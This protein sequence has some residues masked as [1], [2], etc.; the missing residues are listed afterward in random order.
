MSLANV[1]PPYKLTSEDLTQNADHI[2]DPILKAIHKYE[3]HPSV[4][5]IKEKMTEFN[6]HIFS[7]KKLNENEIKKQICSLKSS[8][9]QQPNDIPTQLI[10]EN[11]DIFV[12]LSQR[13]LTSA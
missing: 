7:F 11:I 6:F 10:K 4:I 13:I 9:A 12:L 1:N 5:K 2:D 3:L 8:K